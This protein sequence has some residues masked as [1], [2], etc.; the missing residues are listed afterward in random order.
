MG[1]TVFDFDKEN[2]VKRT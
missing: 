2:E 1:G